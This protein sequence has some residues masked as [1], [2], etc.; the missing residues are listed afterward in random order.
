MW[1]SLYP[2]TTIVKSPVQE[3]YIKGMVICVRGYL[4]LTASS[5]SEVGSGIFVCCLLTLYIQVRYCIRYMNEYVWEIGFIK[6]LKT[7]TKLIKFFVKKRK[8]RVGLYLLKPRTKYMGCN[9]KVNTFFKF[10]TRQKTV[11]C[12]QIHVNF[13][14]HVSDGIHRSIHCLLRHPRISAE[15]RGARWYNHFQDFFVLFDLFFGLILFT[16]LLI[17]RVRFRCR[18]LLQR[19]CNK[20]GVEITIK[21]G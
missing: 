12:W 13:S 8:V 21:K 3:V 14:V 17:D 5:S 1:G 18:L 19:S 15:I 10:Y 6:S 2:Q 11:F 7:F 20:F 9:H 16:R 4:F